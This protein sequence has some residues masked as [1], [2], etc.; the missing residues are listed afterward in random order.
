M[1]RSSKI[2]TSVVFS[3]INEKLLLNGRTDGNGTEIKII[4]DSESRWDKDGTRQMIER[5]LWVVLSP[6][7]EGE[8]ISTAAGLVVAIEGKVSE[9]LI[10]FIKSRYSEEE[11]AR[12]IPQITRDGKVILPATP[13][14]KKYLEGIKAEER[15][16]KV[17]A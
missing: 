1:V 8:V 4:T 2:R 12:L 9:W 10:E 11:A 14:D 17:Q 3:L 13:V 6:E 15:I 7:K 5:I 16:Y